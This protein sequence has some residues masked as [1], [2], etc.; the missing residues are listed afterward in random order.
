M[1]WGPGTQEKNI[2][3]QFGTIKKF[4][5]PDTKLLTKFRLSCFFF[6]Y[7]PKKKVSL[8][9]HRSEDPFWH[10]SIQRMHQVD[11]GLVLHC[12]FCEL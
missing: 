8:Y 1:D 7:Q 11:R 9:L 6:Y 4:L 10:V 2:A 5:G 3:A 12:N